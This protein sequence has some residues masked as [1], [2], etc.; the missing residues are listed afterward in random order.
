MYQTE[1]QK[2]HA[3]VFC[4]TA[5]SKIGQGARKNLDHINLFVQNISKGLGYQLVPHVVEGTEFN[6]EKV[7]QVIEE[8]VKSITK[9]DVIIL[10]INSH[11]YKSVDDTDEFPRIEIGGKLMSSFH[12][13]E[14]LCRI[15]HRL[16]LSLV[17]ACSEYKQLD[18][19]DSFLISN[20]YS[21]ARE[22]IMNELS[23]ATIK[24]YNYRGFF[25]RG[26]S[27][28]V[29]AGQAGSLTYSSSE[30]SYFTSS[31]IRAF[32]EAVDTSNHLIDWGGLLK[33][34]S[35]YTFAT[36][37]YLPTRPCPIWSYESC[38]SPQKVHMDTSARYDYGVTVESVYSGHKTAE[39][40]KLYTCFF[41]PEIDALL[42]SVS[43]YLPYR[44]SEPIVTLHA[45]DSVIVRY[46]NSFT[47]D[48]LSKMEL[49]GNDFNFLDQTT[50]GF[51]FLAKIYLKNGR[52]EEVYMRVA[53]PEE[54]DWWMVHKRKLILYFLF[55]IVL[56]VTAFLIF[57][58]YHTKT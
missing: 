35:N 10:Y 50:E 31:F 30:G 49:R 22:K 32:Y 44:S 7:T 13:H 14:Q 11:G 39:G 53:W 1:A 48:S 41:R 45:S 19:Q 33:K 25:N 3:F 4:N 36:T 23:T 42:D 40:K 2:L 8:G 26:G 16:L 38:G 17:D 51:P 9:L 6:Q 54:P 56:V 55:S 28:I 18:N 34:A 27:F 43:Y 46:P 21:A 57:R 24:N 5:D 12:I 15:E 58:K 37:R 20:T 47:I 52:E 29:S